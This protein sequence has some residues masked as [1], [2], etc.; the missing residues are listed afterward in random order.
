AAGAAP[1]TAPSPP[2][3]V[4]PLSES[5]SCRLTQRK[6][7]AYEKFRW[8]PEACEMPEFEASQFLR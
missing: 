8:Q 3:L 4:V 5:W 1:A 2:N 6:D 7:F